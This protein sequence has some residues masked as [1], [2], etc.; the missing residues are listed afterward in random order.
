MPV[1]FVELTCHG[2]RIQITPG[3]GQGS[4]PRVLER[5]LSDTN[6]VVEARFG[7]VGKSLDLDRTSRSPPVLGNACGVL[8]FLCFWS[9]RFTL[10]TSPTQV[11]TR[12]LSGNRNRNRVLWHPP[13]RMH[14][15]QHAQHTQ[16]AGVG[17]MSLGLLRGYPGI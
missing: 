1:W 2:P 12:S 15:V 8:G 10:S 4:G 6:E 14:R 11:P 13:L 9:V 7:R 3:T 5:G 16:Y 17:G